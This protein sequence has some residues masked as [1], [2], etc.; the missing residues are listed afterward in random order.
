[1]RNLSAFRSL[2]S[3]HQPALKWHHDE[4]QQIANEKNNQSANITGYT[5]PDDTTLPVELLLR[6]FAY[7]Q[8]PDLVRCRSVCKR[9]RDA[10]DGSSQTQYQIELYVAGY[11]DDNDHSSLGGNGPRLEALKQEIQSWKNPRSS[12]QPTDFPWSIT[13]EQLKQ[14]SWHDN[15]WI[16]C[17]AVTGSQPSKWNALQCVLLESSL[18]GTPT[19]QQWSHSFPFSFICASADPAQG[20]ALLLDVQPRGSDGGQNYVIWTI[21]IRDGHVNSV[22]TI[23]FDGPSHLVWREVEIGAKG[24]GV[25]IARVA[26]PD[27]Q[28]RL[29]INLTF[30]NM[31]DMRV[32][33]T[34]TQTTEPG[35]VI[36]SQHLLD[37]CVLLHVMT[38]NHFVTEV[39]I[40]LPLLSQDSADESVK[41]RFHHVATY[42]YPD[43]LPK[44][45]SLGNGFVTGSS[46][47][48]LMPGNTATYPFTRQVTDAL[49][50]V[51]R[52]YVTNA[53][54][55]RVVHLFPASAITSAI[56]S[57]N[58]AVG[59][60]SIPWDRWGPMNSRCFIDHSRM[61]TSSYGWQFVLPDF[62]M[63]DFNP[64]DI[65][66][67]L[68][69]AGHAVTPPTY[70]RKRGP[71]VARKHR[72]L[73]EFLTGVSAHP[74]PEPDPHIPGKGVI[75][76]Q[77]TLIKRGD[78]FMQDVVT[79]LP[80]RETKLQWTHNSKPALIFGGEVWVACAVP[81]MQDGS[82]KHACY[83]LSVR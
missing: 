69:H 28:E 2:L 50:F 82:V 74:H 39:Y 14:I 68:Q 57:Y 48:G 35:G 9:F 66:R 26:G 24:E 42:H 70:S 47:G 6:V 31:S 76:R 44:Y 53:Q 78:I 19:V 25:C 5:K 16:R 61:I 13:F 22:T 30:L 3:R 18:D 75:I 81:E 65:A 80:Y 77:A 38:N 15:L 8:A 64:V 36:A 17:K 34:K 49:V 56:K 59:V 11:E 21:S 83:M 45:S 79:W 63:L 40:I 1:M 37:F 54:F 20:V 10:I 32:I 52:I 46:G 33:S 60:R 43:V 41:H 29:S 27:P 73:K 12:W 67:D 7:L 55:T 4:S 72:S 23:P 58:P 71:V 62:T 51:T